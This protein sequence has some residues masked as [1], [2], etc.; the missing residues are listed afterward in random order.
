[1]RRE[2]LLNVEQVAQ[3]L[4]CSKKTLYNLRTRHQGPPAIKIGGILRFRPCDVESWLDE[5]RDE[6]S[7]R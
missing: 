5:H 6:G 3:Y 2:G 7:G 4:G 1:M